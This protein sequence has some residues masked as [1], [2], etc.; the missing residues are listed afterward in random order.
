MDSDNKSN[1]LNDNDNLDEIKKQFNQT[2]SKLDELEEKEINSL[3]EMPNMM[4][5][6]TAKVIDKIEMPNFN[7]LSTTRLDLSVR[8]STINKKKD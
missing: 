7:L 3:Y 5:K 4:D 2:I 8:R 6:L 1:Q